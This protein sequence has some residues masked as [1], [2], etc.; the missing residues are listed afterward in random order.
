MVDDKLKV[1]G[2]REQIDFSGPA[3]ASTTVANYYDYLNNLDGVLDRGTVSTYRFEEDESNTVLYDYGC[4]MVE[5][6]DEF[7]VPWGLAE[8]G[9]VNTYE[10]DD[11]YYIHM[12]SYA[13]AMFLARYMINLFNAGCTNM[14]VCGN[15]LCGLEV[16]YRY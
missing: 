10:S 7:D 15:G 12:D 9:T 16:P 1:E 3:D 2:I 4:A 6:C 14:K 11:E 5:T 13:R 8:F